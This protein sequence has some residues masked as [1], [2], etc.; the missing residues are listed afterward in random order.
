MKITKAVQI[1]IILLSAITPTVLAQ[2]NNQF[3]HIYDFEDESCCFYD[4]FAEH[5]GNIAVC[6]RAMTGDR[7][8]AGFWLME[9]ASNGDILWQDIYYPD[10]V[11]QWFCNGF[12]II[13]TDDG[14][15]VIGGNESLPGGGESI[16]FAVTKI[17]ANHEQVWWCDYFENRQILCKAVIET[18]DQN[19]LAAGYSGSVVMIGQ[20]DGAVIWENVYNDYS[21]IYSIRET[22]DGYILAGGGWIFKI[23]DEG[24]V[25]W[26]QRIEG[27]IIRSMISC[28]NGFM[29]SGYTEGVGFRQYT[30]WLARVD[31]RGEMQWNHRYF[32]QGL[33]HWM[34][35]GVGLAQ[36]PFGGFIM[37]GDNYSSW[38]LRVDQAGNEMWQRV[39]TLGEA[40]QGRYNEYHSIVIA[41]DGFPVV[42]GQIDIGDDY[43]GVIVKVIPDRSPP[44]I[45]DFQPESTEITVIRGDSVEF[46]VQAV[47]WQ[48]DSLS[49]I[50]TVGNEEVSTDTSVT[51]TFEEFGRDTITCVVSDGELTTSQQWFVNVVELYIESFQPNTLS[52]AVHR[53]AIVNFS[54]TSRAVDGDPVE[55][56]WLFDDEEV[57]DD[58]S[59]SIRFEH[60]RDHTVEAIAFRGE[61]ADS[62]RWHVQIQDLIVD[63][64][65]RDL[66][67]SAYMDTSLQFGVIPLDPENDT[68]S[69]LWELNGDSIADGRRVFVDFDSA[70]IYELTAYVSDTT[71]SDS[72]TW[73]VTVIPNSVDAKDLSQLPTVPTLY[74]T[75]PNPFNSQTT[76]RYYLPTAS[77]VRLELFDINGRLVNELAS[78]QESIG[79]HSVFINGGDLVSG[80]YFV[81]M[82]VEREMSMRK[83][84][85][86]K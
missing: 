32:I 76:V 30:P 29:V 71:E 78:R 45:T 41:T 42:A 15:W 44:V 27:G 4:V 60:E 26:D 16:K 65:P 20:E 23:N 68:L 82:N 52:V 64:W 8:K 56:L 77:Q 13:Q 81:K 80:V 54:V 58:D 49:Y 6:G 59:V 21:S 1:I 19:I 5:N 83:L 50:W 3:V 62:V 53:N 11:R 61:H 12:S 36:V 35:D 22:D 85:L 46:A 75:S 37:C 86:L 10:G 63:Y 17:A 84:I 57:A 43:R 33:G 66:E 79:Y 55:Y 38:L 74:S 34:I 51:I 48:D 47:D 73:E 14:G 72:L 9:T 39:D 70:G 2:P 69:Y 25:L 24:D 28:E 18:K 40:N 7:R 31:S 67:L